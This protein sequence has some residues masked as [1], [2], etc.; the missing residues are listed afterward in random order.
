MKATYEV[1]LDGDC[2]VWHHDYDSAKDDADSLSS[3]APHGVTIE[4]VRVLWPHTSEET[5][6]ETRCRT[7][8]AK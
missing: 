5:T 8:V 2:Y 7:R 1:M 3:T 4:I 6:N